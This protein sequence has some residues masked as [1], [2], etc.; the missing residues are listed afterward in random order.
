MAFIVCWPT[1]W[2][3]IK[4]VRH[5][6]TSTFWSPQQDVPAQEKVLDMS[7][8]APSMHCNPVST[9]QPATPEGGQTATSNNSL[10]RLEQTFEDL[11]NMCSCD[12]FSP[13]SLRRQSISSPTC[14]CCSSSGKCYPRIIHTL[15]C[16]TEEIRELTG[17]ENHKNHK[18][19]MQWADWWRHFL[20]LWNRK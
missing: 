15:S 13:W 17:L 7:K 20:F 12:T 3:M 9:P 11:M 1:F 4:T 10:S 2:K 18:C 5:G 19:S 16:E 14:R 6:S 8:V